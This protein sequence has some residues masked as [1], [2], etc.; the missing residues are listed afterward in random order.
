MKHP[1]VSQLRV[2]VDNASLGWSIGVPTVIFENVSAGI[3]TVSIEHV[4]GKTPSAVSNFR[5][6]AIATT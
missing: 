5:L 1:Q 3:H 2:S 6:I 4:R